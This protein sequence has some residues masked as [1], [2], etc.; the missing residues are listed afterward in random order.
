MS[1]GCLS[2]GLIACTV[3]QCHN[4]NRH[5]RE[6]RDEEEFVGVQNAHPQQHPHN[7]PQEQTHNRVDPVQ[8]EQQQYNEAVAASLAA[9]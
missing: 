2:I 1:M 4:D 8:L 9:S 7:I 3:K 5:R 6:R